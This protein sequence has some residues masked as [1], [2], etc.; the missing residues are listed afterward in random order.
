MEKVSY[1]MALQANPVNHSVALKAAQLVEVVNMA[2]LPTNIPDLQSGNPPGA[3]HSIH[4]GILTY[5]QHPAVAHKTTTIF[6]NSLTKK[7]VN[8]KEALMVVQVDL[9]VAF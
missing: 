4:Y 7:N 5:L 6:N 9:G 1:M 8:S 2:T 3:Q